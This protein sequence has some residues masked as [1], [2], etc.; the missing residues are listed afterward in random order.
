MSQQ[1]SAQCG[2]ERDPEEL[3]VARL[4]VTVD[5]GP[6][7]VR[8]ALKPILIQL[9]ARGLRAAFFNLGDEVRRDRQSTAA[10]QY[11]GHV[12]GNH[13]WDHL[14]PST[15]NFT[16]QEIID[17]FRRTHREV[18]IAANT[19]MQHW[20]APRLE[21]IS[22]LSGLLVGSGKLYGLSHCDV[23]A[24][25][26][27]SQGVV[28]AAGMLTAL[29]RDIRAQPGRLI[30]RLLFHV[31]V[32]TANSLPAVLNGLLADGHSLVDFVQTT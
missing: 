31:K 11:Y 27:D 22:R 26:R 23:H 17:Q 18:K 20:R 21:Q 29:R 4:Q 6:L 3:H 1:S 28:D 24:D 5:D 8:A 2:L 7:P 14:T 19:D 32:E 9:A 30:F 16:D 15:A 10:I 13:S 25:S 12:L